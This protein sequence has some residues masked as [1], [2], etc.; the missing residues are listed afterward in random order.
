MLFVKA[1]FSVR[2]NVRIAGS[3]VYTGMLCVGEGGC[4]LV[5]LSLVFSSR[6]FWCVVMGELWLCNGPQVE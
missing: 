2:P 4:F 5:G 3:I 6:F 1:R